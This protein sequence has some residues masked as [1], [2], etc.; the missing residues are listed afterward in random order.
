MRR[1][2]LLTAATLLLCAGCSTASTGRAS[3]PSVDQGAIVKTAT[4]TTSKGTARMDQKIVI[5]GG[6]VDA[7]IAVTGNVDFAGDKATLAVDFPQGGI[8]HVDEVL[9]GKQAYIRGA[10]GVDEATWAVG[11]RDTAQAHY[12]LRAPLND[13]QH[14]LRQISAMHHVSKEGDEEVAGV[15][16]S[17]YRGMLDHE[18]LTLR[19]APETREKVEQARD[20]LGNDLPAY[21]EAWVDQQG[22]VVQTR[23]SMDL[24]GARVTVTTALGDLGK[25]VRVSLPSADDTVPATG[26]TGILTG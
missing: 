23:T 11:S 14:V 21:A 1:H 7:T 12:I 18:T 3:E 19:M 9:V 16:T 6:G 17:R 22:R 2:I 4:A 13:P 26:F 5:A 15:G 20:L 8:S 24:G 10:A 25:P